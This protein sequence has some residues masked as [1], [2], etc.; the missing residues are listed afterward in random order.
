M[1]DK[2]INYHSLTNQEIL[3]E[4]VAFHVILNAS[5]LVEDLFNADLLSMDD[6]ENY[7][8]Y[9]CPA[10]GSEMIL[11]DTKVAYKYFCTA[12]DHSQKEEPEQETQEIYEWWFVTEWL[13]EKLKAR[14]EPVIDSKYGYLWG[15]G[16]TGQAILLDGVMG[17]IAEELEILEGQR[18]DWSKRG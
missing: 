9:S 2:N 8:F 12:C 3:G 14:N 4:F 1:T 13:Y 11:R 10:C 18:S 17:K 16:A 6:V 15:R 7:H 5:V